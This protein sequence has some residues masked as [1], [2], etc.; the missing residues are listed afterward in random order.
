M[1]LLKACFPR[2][3]RCV[4]FR[5]G[6]WLIAWVA[7]FAG[8]CRTAAALPSAKEYQIKAVF[9][10]NFAQ[11]VDWPPEAFPTPETPVIIG[12]LGEDPFGSLLEETIMGE[13]IDQHPLLIRRYHRVEDID[14][15]HILFISG[16][17]TNRLESTMVALQDRGI[18][19]VCDTE[20][21]AKRGVM[22]RFIN[23]KNKIRLRINLER[24]KAAGLVLSSKLLRPSEIISS[25][26]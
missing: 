15:C 9:L 2:F 16:S 7:L 12:V 11:F 19:T 13:R 14:L 26:P 24:V 6:F 22:I 10:F 21:F 17:E 18:L 23:E 5:R 3:L 1:A 4:L 8:S 20:G 25:S